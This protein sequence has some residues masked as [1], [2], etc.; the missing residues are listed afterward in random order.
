MFGL[1]ARPLLKRQC[2][3]PGFYIP[4]QA[5]VSCSLSRC[6]SIAVPRHAAHHV[7]R[8][9]AAMIPSLR[10]TETSSPD[11]GNVTSYPAARLD[12][13]SH[14]SQ[15]VCTCI[16]CRHGRDLDFDRQ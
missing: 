16:D 8:S 15:D 2:Y 5:D 9:A 7:R 1:Q 4:T 14:P 10:F 13:D 3:M 6:S 11:A 12:G